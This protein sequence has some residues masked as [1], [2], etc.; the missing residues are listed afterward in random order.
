MKLRVL[1]LSGLSLNARGLQGRNR[2]C[3]GKRLYFKVLPV[4]HE[5]SR[6]PPETLSLHIKEKAPTSPDTLIGKNCLPLFSKI[7][8]LFIWNAGVG[9]REKETDSIQVS[10]MSARTQVLESW[11]PDAASQ[12][13]HKQ[14]AR[15][16]SRVRTQIQAVQYGLWISQEVS[17][18][19]C[20]MPNFF[21]SKWILLENI[22]GSTYSYM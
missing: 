21:R 2:T 12:G 17:S 20:Q 10:H 8:F 14:E 6:F 1:G 18:L 11:S 3:S 13:M 22:T 5:H 9:E 7:L 16:R 15:L 4:H 19:L